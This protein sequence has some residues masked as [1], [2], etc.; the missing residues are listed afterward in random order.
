MIHLDYWSLLVRVGVGRVREF[1]RCVHVVACAP[2]KPK[3]DPPLYCYSTYINSSDE[4]IRTE[5]LL[6][7]PRLVLIHDLLADRDIDLMVRQANKQV[8]SLLSIRIVFVNQ[9]NSALPNLAL[10]LTLTL[11]LTLT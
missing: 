3:N 9:E 4:Y 11:S 5:E 8:S 6:V 10:T 7:K 1:P 2:Q